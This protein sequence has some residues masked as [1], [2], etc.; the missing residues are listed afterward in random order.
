MFRKMFQ[1]LNVLTSFKK[2]IHVKITDLFLEAFNTKFL[3][4]RKKEEKFRKFT[5]NSQ[6]E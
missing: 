2:R 5:I 4:F 3:S 6:N 1:K